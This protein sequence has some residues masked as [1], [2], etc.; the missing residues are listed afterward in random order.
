MTKIGLF[1]GSFN[2][3]HLGHIQS[4]IDVTDR[5]ELEKVFV[6]P[7]YLNPHKEPIE[8]PSPEQRLEITKV[9]MEDYKEFVNVDEQ[10]ILRKGP[11]FTVETLQTYLE[12]YTPE[13]IHLI[14]G[15]DTFSS[16][17]TWKDFEFIVKN[18]NLIVTS[19]PGNQLPF[20]IED[21]PKGLRP[22]VAAFDRNYIELTTERHIEFVRIEDVDV[23]ATEVRK[24]LR[25]GQRVEKYLSYPVEEYI[26]Q[27]KLYEP[28]GDK[29]PDYREFSIEC[30]KKL[31]DRGGLNTKA[32]DLTMLD[33]PA[34]Y[35][36][37]TSGTSSRNSSA[38]AEFIQS[39]IK[40]EYGVFP[41]AVEGAK[42][43]RWVVLDYGALIVHVFYDFAR[44]EYRLEDLWKEG[45]LMYGLGVESSED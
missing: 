29:I 34:E 28:L 20:S 5:L 22:Y 16:F 8:G 36:I 37:V 44:Q 25:T 27:N 45:E 24:K 9:G 41:L 13:E 26:R 32:F 23:S 18:A 17:D 4:V 43:G 10:E 2:P 7:A 40:E 15:M 3:I 6:I 30:A 14:L 1:G 12:E 21:I 31:N 19:R 38:L 42:E 33:Y 11:S 35:T 39:K